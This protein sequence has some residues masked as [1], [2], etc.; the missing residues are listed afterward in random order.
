MRCTLFLT[1]GNQVVSTRACVPALRRLG[2][3]R[4]FDKVRH[5]SI[6]SSIAT[7]KGAFH[8]I[9]RLLAESG[10]RTSVARGKLEE[11]RRHLSEFPSISRRL[12]LIDLWFRIGI[13]H[14]LPSEFCPRNN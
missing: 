3:Y 5:G 6:S 9:G 11:I 14:L 12:C 1:K 13:L 4:S 7:A 8:T 2:M 10:T